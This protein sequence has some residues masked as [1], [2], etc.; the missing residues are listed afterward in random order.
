M[1]AKARAAD[2]SEVA[3]AAFWQLLL[4]LV[5]EGQSQAVSVAAVA[6]GSG[7]L[8]KQPHASKEVGARQAP[9]VP[10]QLLVEEAM[11]APRPPTLRIAG[12][13]AVVPTDCSYCTIAVGNGWLHRGLQKRSDADQV[14][15]L[16][17]MHIPAADAMG[18]AVDAAEDIGVT[19]I[20]CRWLA[21]AVA[22]NP[23]VC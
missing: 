16:H 4:P 5:R 8:T 9:Q 20:D 6:A 18:R 7:P 11:A 22:I 2:A 13:A 10:A 1:E 19:G 23:V 15:P 21:G 17:T 3:T 12:A 14:L